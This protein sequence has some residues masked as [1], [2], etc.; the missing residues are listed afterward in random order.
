MTGHPGDLISAWL[1]GEL[2]PSEAATIAAHLE[3]C[4]ACA[5]ERDEVDSARVAVRGL[6]L[7]MPPLGVLRPLPA[8]HV[9]DLISARLDGEVEADLLPGLDAH[10]AACPAC[11]AEHEEVAWAR[12]AL[13]GLPSVD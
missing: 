12:A 1:D 10:V 13:R 3:A 7:L 9:G 8:M 5:A 6:P 2:A 11:T 4:P